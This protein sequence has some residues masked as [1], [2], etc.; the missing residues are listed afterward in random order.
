[1]KQIVSGNFVYLAY[2][3]HPITFV[4]QDSKDVFQLEFV[5]RKLVHILYSPKNCS[6][7]RWAEKNS[8]ISFS[9]DHDKQ[10]HQVLLRSPDFHVRVDY[11]G[12]RGVS[13]TWIDPWSSAIFAEDLRNRAYAYDAQSNGVYHYMRRKPGS[14]VYCGLG[15]RTGQLNLHGRRFHLEG[16]D[17]MGYD[18]E[19]TDPLYKFCPF[20]ITL[21]KESGMAYGIFY[22]NLCRTILDLG[23]EI[24]ALWGPYRY[25]HA[26]SGPLNYY[27]CL[28]PSVPVVFDGFASLMGR[29]LSLPPRYSLGYLASS[30][31][32]SEASNAQEKLAGFPSVCRKNDIPCDGLHLSSGYTVS[33]LTGERYV[34]TWNYERFPDPRALVEHLKAHGIHVFANMKPWLLRTHP[35]YEYLKS[36]KGFMWDADNDSPAI[37]MQWSS[38]AGTCAPASYIDFTSNVGYNFWKNSVKEQLLEYGVE[39]CWN[40]NNEFTLT[41]DSCTFAMEILPESVADR[42]WDPQRKAKPAGVVGGPIQTL[43]MAQCSFEAMQEWDPNLRPFVITRSTSP[44]IHRFC[45]QTWSGDNFTDWKTLKFNI[46]MGL[47]AGLSICPGG[48]GHDVGGFAGPKP[49]PELLQ[50]WVQAGIL[51]PRF[52]IHSWNDDNS[53]TEPW[54]YETIVANIRRSIQFRMSLI[55][56]LYSLVVDFHRT[57]RPNMR[58]LFWSFQH[59]GNTFEQGFEY[60]LGDSLLVAPVFEEGAKSRTVYL[61]LLSVTRRELQNAPRA[62]VWFHYQSGCSYAAGKEVTVEAPVD[63]FLPPVFIPQ[64]GMIP[65][66]RFMHHVGEVPDDCRIV[67]LFPPLIAGHGT[68]VSGSSRSEVTLYD[69]DGISMKYHQEDEFSEI[70]VWMQTYSGSVDVKVGL[71]VINDR[72]RPPYTKV[73]VMVATEESKQRNI[74]VDGVSVPESQLDEQGRAMVAIPLATRGSLLA[75]GR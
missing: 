18:A 40:D 5:T 53:V 75:K 71:K 55:P 72:Y 6:A 59:D 27:M 47:S 54:M 43:L 16:F 63:A 32:Y 69:D 4:S 10:M 56:F 33:P 48:Y 70:T 46:P 1:M 49:S 52:C 62:S 61:P 58:P 51:N 8:P 17:A 34:F 12:E 38:G 3:S 13:L 57:A 26:L 68:G 44:W 60:M 30:M 50:R 15:E 7:E 41:D 36:K 28:G 20:Y 65:L 67:L 29:P 74:V 24:D 22:Q 31:G 37:V 23:A 42:D 11:G 25:Y 45:A 19:R 2:M 9:I 66:G 64:G 39:G 35:K 73:W 21:S 14:E